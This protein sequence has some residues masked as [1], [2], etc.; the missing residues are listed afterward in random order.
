MPPCAGMIQIRFDGRSLEQLP[1]SPAYRTPVFEDILCPLA[2]PPARRLLLFRTM[3]LAFPEHVSHFSE[4]V[5]R[6]CGT[7]EQQLA[8]DPWY[9]SWRE[10]IDAMFRRTKKPPLL[11]MPAFRCR[12][13][14]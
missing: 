13:H 10:R 4:Q 1:L 8:L 12:V 14:R 7:S 5:S 3:S 11:N 9:S 6:F 2:P